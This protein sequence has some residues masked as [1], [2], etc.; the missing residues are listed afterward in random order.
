MV[1][2]NRRLHKENSDTSI[3]SSSRVLSVVTVDTKYHPPNVPSSMISKCMRA[4]YNN[5]RSLIKG[6]P[7]REDT[8]RKAN[9]LPNTYG[10]WKGHLR[11]I[12][13]GIVLFV[14]STDVLFQSDKDTILQKFL[15]TGSRILFSGEHACFPMKYWPWNMD[16]GEWL[17]K[18]GCKGACSNSR[19]V[20]DHLFPKSV[21]RADPGNKWLN[22]GCIIG[23]AKDLKRLMD[24]LRVLPRELIETW[25]GGDQGLY[26][27]AALSPVEHRNRLP[28]KHFFSFGFVDDQK[29]E[30]VFTW[31]QHLWS[32]GADN[33]LPSQHFNADGKQYMNATFRDTVASKPLVVQPNVYA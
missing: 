14:D 8:E 2:T 17:Y 26:A 5:G 23:Y 29:E 31:G 18:D 20:C 30:N 25:G 1:A 21:N 16:L 4:R 3:K 22:S 13:T 15:S 6:Q 28:T 10:R 12:L 33:H 32:R 7:L 24:D 19:F 11:K 27:Y 9:L